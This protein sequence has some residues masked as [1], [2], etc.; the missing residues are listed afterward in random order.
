VPLGDGPERGAYSGLERL[1]ENGYSGVLHCELKVISPLI[2][3]DHRQAEDEEYQFL[4][5]DKG[6]VII[7][8]SSLKG[9]TRAVYE[10]LVDGCMPLAQTTYSGGDKSK[11]PYHYK[12][13]KKHHGKECNSVDFLC[14]ACQ[15]FGTI[16]GDKT[17]CQSRIRFTD[18]VLT[19]G[20][21]R[22][23][24]C[25]LRTLLSPKP[26]HNQNY[27]LHGKGGGTIAGRKFYYHHDEATDFALDR[28]TEYSKTIRDYAP[29][30]ALFSF[31]VH[32]QDLTPQELGQLILTLELDT[33]LGHKLGLGKAIGMGSCQIT[34]KDDK[35]S[36]YHPKQ[37]YEQWPQS[38]YSSSWREHKL[39][40]SHLPKMLE[41]I[42]RLN[43]S[44]DG[45]IGYPNH[46]DYKSGY[47]N[48]PIDEKGFF[49]EAEHAATYS[50]AMINKA[51][52]PIQKGQE[53]EG[54]LYKKGERW[55]AKFI[56]DKR[57]AIVINFREVPESTPDG[58][59]A[60]FFITEQSKR[61]GIKARFS[62]IINTSKDS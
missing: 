41:Q 7:Q 40:R 16:E 35:S 21:P 33:G 18:A 4:R 2:S 15:L 11:K 30:G 42:L 6:K 39:S 46:Q 26:H 12:D 34:I 37:R 55:S 36:I 54:E 47:A 17:H 59:R 50:Q 29:H 22:T 10:A 49:G 44:R 5:T 32:I 62:K 14:R 31:N 13:L 45:D 25:H 43:K 48:K 19:S 60:E 9:M 53:I 58:A 57:E 24:K 8:G 3:I 38:E 23:E 27:G 56:G 28:P 52:K 51:P 61:A 1:R 20:G